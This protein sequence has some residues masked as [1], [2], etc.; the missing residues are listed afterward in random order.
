MI[1]IFQTILEFAQEADPVQPDPFIKGI[2]PFS[3]KNPKWK[4]VSE[5]PKINFSSYY[6]QQAEQKTPLQLCRNLEGKF[7]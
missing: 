1:E 7:S 3:I 2:W 6:P 5:R 4:K